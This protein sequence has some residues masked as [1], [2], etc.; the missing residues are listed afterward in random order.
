MKK[1]IK[2]SLFLITLVATILACGYKTFGAIHVYSATSGYVSQFY[3]STTDTILADNV[4][5]F[6]PDGKYK[7]LVL[8][9]G[10]Q[11][12]LSG[13]YG[14]EDAG[15]EFTISIDTDGDSKFDD[16]LYPDDNLSYFEWHH[17]SNILK[18]YLAQ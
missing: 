18:Y 12:N 10:K 7:A 8:V 11:T 16:D 9:D 17:N 5:V 6:Y 15:D 1:R 13:K 14:A 4:W 3:N 2:L